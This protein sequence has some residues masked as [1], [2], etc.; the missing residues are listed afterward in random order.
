MLA[1]DGSIAP[2]L[3]TREIL[4][5]IEQGSEET[6]SAATSARMLRDRLATLH[7]ISS[8]RI[9][10]FPHDDDRLIG[11]AAIRPLAPWL[12]F[13]PGLPS[14]GLS[15]L[16]QDICAIER[17]DRFRIESEQIA[18]MP[19]G[20]VALV[21][22]PNDPTGTSLS[23]AQAAQLARRC[24]LLVLDERSAE[25]QRRSMI[26]LVEEFDSIVLLR[27][28]SDWAGLGAN[29]PGYAIGTNRIAAAIDRSDQLDAYGLR[30]A[31]AAVSNS[32][33]LDAIA[34]RVR[35]ER[36]RLY[37]MLRK[38]NFLAPYPSDAGYVLARV[39]RGNR[40][41]IARALLDRDIAVFS[42]QQPRLQ[43]TLRFTAVS[44]AATQ[45]L[46]SAL[47]DI[48]RSDIG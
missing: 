43:E 27:S 37:R 7:G 36:L 34:H 5:A 12:V 9:A 31:L 38:L 29:V 17:N 25:M 19:G 33:A 21:M 6:L 15:A 48:A 1:L 40:D 28:F 14:L 46:Q 13:E 4:A 3:P 47:I 24:A 18:A 20:A 30:A 16:T 39:T 42:P 26:P 10:L 44:P 32:A 2:Y 41:Q 45:K 35:L 23:V 8:D 11:I 22:T